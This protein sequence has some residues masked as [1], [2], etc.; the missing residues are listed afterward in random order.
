LDE[1]MDSLGLPIP[2]RILGEFVNLGHLQWLMELDAVNHQ[3]GFPRSLEE[4]N[5]VLFWWLYRGWTPVDRPGC[6]WVRK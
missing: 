6:D 3:E 5:S 1:R 4:G 2:R